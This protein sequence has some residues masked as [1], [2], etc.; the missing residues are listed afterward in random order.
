MDL[1]DLILYVLLHWSDWSEWYFNLT[2]LLRWKWCI[3]GFIKTE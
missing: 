3:M 2:S 1:P